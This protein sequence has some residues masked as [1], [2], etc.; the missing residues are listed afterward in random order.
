TKSFVSALVLGL[1]QDGALALDDPVGKFLPAFREHGEGPFDRRK[2]TIRHLMS[3]TSGAAVDGEKAPESLPP[4]FGNI[5]IVS[6]PGGDYRYSG[7]GMLILE[8]AIEA[9]TGRDFGALLDERVI[10]P[11][12]LDST[13]YVYAG[14]ASERVL[15]LRPGEYEYSRNGHRAS[16]GLFTNARD[17]NAFG[18]FWLDTQSAFSADLR[19]EA[20]TWHGTRATDEGRYG[21]MWWLFEAD[22]GYVMSGRESKINAVVPETGVVVTVIR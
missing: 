21:L 6:E 16:E 1:C 19:K 4:G 9:A 15:P 11:L 22:G 14:S 20:W 2:V 12:G 7:L 13:G 3:H 17:L 18:R 8:R 5:E 10:R